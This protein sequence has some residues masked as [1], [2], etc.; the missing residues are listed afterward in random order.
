MH[1][2]RSPQALAAVATRET[3]HRALL[4]IQREGFQPVSDPIGVL[5]ELAGEAV[6]LKDLLREH[7]ARLT[8]IRYQAGAGE[9][10]RGELQAYGQAFDRAAKLC[11]ALAKLGLDERAVRVTEEQVDQMEHALTAALLVIADK[12]LRAEVLRE[13]AVQLRILAAAEAVA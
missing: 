3:E 10:V 12:S 4:A 8:E 9:M 11:E 13:M 7:V 2:G 6:A 5:R 1:G